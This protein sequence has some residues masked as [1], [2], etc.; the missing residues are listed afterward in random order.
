[1]PSFPKWLD[2]AGLLVSLFSGIKCFFVF[3][4][5]LMKCFMEEKKKTQQMLLG[6]RNDQMWF[7]NCEVLSLHRT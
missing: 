7:V 6:F 1:M 3:C 5:A 4:S 2:E